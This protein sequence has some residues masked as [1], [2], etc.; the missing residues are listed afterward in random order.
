MWKWILRTL[1]SQCQ[2]SG[3]SYLE[4]F[5]DSHGPG[6]TAPTRCRNGLLKAQQHTLLLHPMTHLNV[7]D[8]EWHEMLLEPQHE[9][10]SSNALGASLVWRI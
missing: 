6:W 4:I 1:A 9:M 3:K 2:V 8:I 7:K 5:V 10:C